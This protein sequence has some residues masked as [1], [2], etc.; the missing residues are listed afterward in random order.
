M[1]KL[2]KYVFGIIL[3]SAISYG[4]Y[5]QNLRSN[6]QRKLQQK[7]FAAPAA[8]KVTRQQNL[9]LSKIQVVK[10]AFLKEELG[11][12]KE[13]DTH[14]WPVYRKYQSELF[15]IR[16]LKRLN[17]SDAQANGAEQVKKDMDY[18]AQLVNIRKHYNE[19]FL[20]ILPS[21]KVSQLL[22]SERAFNDELLRKLHSEKQE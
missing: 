10:E 9:G 16:R 2:Y 3:L 19:E 8:T 18:D 7:N 17:N 14:F 21:E 13:Q 1:T 6:Q 12:T 5:A 11:L 15:E 22:K 4:G 20:K